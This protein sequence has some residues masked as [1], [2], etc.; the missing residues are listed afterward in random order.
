MYYPGRP[1][2]RR[3]SG[4]PAIKRTQ[5]IASLPPEQQ[6]ELETLMA[7]KRRSAASERRLAELW[8]RAFAAHEER[9]RARQQELAERRELIRQ[10][11]EDL[12]RNS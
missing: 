4:Y 7:R 12:A 10:L 8:T 1:D 5:V 9:Q 3:L 11:E 2:P 6:E